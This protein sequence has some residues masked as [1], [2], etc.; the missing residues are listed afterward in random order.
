DFTNWGAPAP[1]QSRTDFT[2]KPT[3]TDVFNTCA[4]Q[5]YGSTTTRQ[6]GTFYAS[7]QSSFFDVNIP[8]NNASGQNMPL[9]YTK[10]NRYNTS[11]FA[12]RVDSLDS[13]NVYTEFANLLIGAMTQDPKGMYAFKFNQ[14]VSGGATQK[15][16]FYYVDNTTPYNTTGATQGAEVYRLAAKALKGQRPRLTTGFNAG[17]GT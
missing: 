16:G 7:D 3:S 8:A 12:S 10:F 15:T 11:T 2:G 9:V 4:V 14:T 5:L 1:Q 17:T 6:P 13:S